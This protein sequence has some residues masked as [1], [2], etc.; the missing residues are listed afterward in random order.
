M[1]IGR[2][3]LTSDL[4]AAL[5]ALYSLA[6]PEL[7]SIDDAAALELLPPGL[8]ALIR[9]AGATPQTARLTHRLLGAATLG[10]SFNVPLRSAAIDDV[11]RRA[12]AQGVQQMVVLG[13]G[14]DARAWR[15]PE[16]ER[17]V[18]F[19]VDHPDTQAYKRQHVGSLA[20]LAREVVF[21]PV[22]FQRE[23]LRVLE[24]RGFARS[25]PSVWIWEGVTMYLQPAAVL[26]TLTALSE[27]S[28][29]NSYL[30]MTYVPDAYAPASV[31]LVG[32]ALF[33]AAGE[34][35]KSTFAPELIGQTVRNAGFMLESDE[36]AVDWAARYWPAAD[37]RRTRAWERLLVAVRRDQV[38]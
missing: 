21:V 22:D 33:G 38:S 4:V 26:A 29:P 36:S 8:R 9:V 37:A 13:A 25:A 11:V 6:P 3:S 27:L 16:L 32:R 23:T 17:V 10:V 5:R 18:V 30:A 24:T 1:R 2:R 19:E 12:C 14:L 7:A 15:L 35:L 20:P 28:A 34:A 31:R